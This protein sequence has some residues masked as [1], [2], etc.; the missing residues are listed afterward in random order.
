[1]E[2]EIITS[3]Q[4]S[5]NEMPPTPREGNGLTNG[6]GVGGAAVTSGAVTNGG[7]MPPPAAEIPLTVQDVEQESD[8]YSV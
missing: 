3:R 5:K 6:H 1:M 4:G 7:E 2:E 8:H